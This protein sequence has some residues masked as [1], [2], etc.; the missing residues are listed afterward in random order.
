M[1]L[2]QQWLTGPA[3][4]VCQALLPVVLVSLHGNPRKEVVFTSFSFTDEETETE[5]GIQSLV[6]DHLASNGR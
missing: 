5:R 3:A 2:S 1:S 4:A 6:E